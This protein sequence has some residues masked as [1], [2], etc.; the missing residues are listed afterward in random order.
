MVNSLYSTRIDFFS[1]RTKPNQFEPMLGSDY[2]GSEK[3]SDQKIISVWKN[4]VT[5]SIRVL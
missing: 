3:N 5:K 1:N 2:F 4:F